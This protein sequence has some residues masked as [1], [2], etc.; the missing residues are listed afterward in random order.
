MGYNIPIPRSRGYNPAESEKKCEVNI[1]GEDF[2]VSDVV[3]H[4]LIGRMTAANNTTYEFGTLYDPVSKT[5]EADIPSCYLDYIETIQVGPNIQRYM[6]WL[7][8][9]SKNEGAETFESVSKNLKS[10]PFVL[11]WT[12]DNLTSIVYDLGSSTITKTLAWISGK[13]V[14]VV[15]SGDIPINIATTKTLAYVGDNLVGATYT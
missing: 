10:Y 8:S 9:L 14:S 13:L 7:Y 5:I 4:A 6:Q 3:L 1:G 2:F 11:N 15:L 12:G